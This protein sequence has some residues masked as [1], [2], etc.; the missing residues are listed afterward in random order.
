MQN[1][2]PATIESH[3]LS[4]PTENSSDRSLGQLWNRFTAPMDFVPVDEHLQIRLLMG[5][6]IIL[7]IL[8]A[9][10][11]IVIPLATGA[12]F[13]PAFLILFGIYFA[14]YALGR[15]KYY[16]VAAILIVLLVDLTVWLLAVA[17]NFTTDV[18]EYLT[19]VEILA[20]LLLS[21]RN[22]SISIVVN[23]IGLII[24]AILQQPLSV[25]PVLNFRLAVYFFT[26]FS[27]L[28]LV[29]LWYRDALERE[30]VRI[31][32]HAEEQRRAAEQ[33]RA[34]D[35]IK[36]RFLASMS[37]EL[38]T[39]LNSVLNFTEFVLNGVFGPVNEEQ[40]DALRT[41]VNS[42]DF[43]LGLINDVLDMTKIES[44]S[45][46]LFIEQVDLRP[47]ISAS[48]ETAKGLIGDKPIAL[49]DN[50]DTSLPTIT[51]DKRRIQQI[52]NNLLSNA[53]KFTPEGIITL[54]A[55]KQGD[56]EIRI[57]VRDSGTGIA[58][59][60]QT[61]IFQPFKQ[62]KQGVQQGSGTGLGLPISRSLAEAHGG[63]LTV[64]SELGQG[65]TFHVVLPVKAREAKPAS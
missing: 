65:A 35:Q 47:I 21:A 38:R 51:G 57:S 22:A 15:T 9:M 16:K 43:L 7:S 39:P 26:I 61:L 23:Y 62:T 12:A 14:I 27:G 50:L 28:L 29:L 40:A 20:V 58:V 42:G 37:H 1:Q 32:L 56:A 13:R 25:N 3:A 52:L 59:T 2:K 54:D 49:I 48:L 18:L 11:T 46:E 55:H 33:V 5:T 44:G 60:D 19:I 24:G 6:I 41:V 64:E 4:Q 8:T 45:L 53:V 34:L 10:I 17:G 31:A 63:T 36:T 30:R